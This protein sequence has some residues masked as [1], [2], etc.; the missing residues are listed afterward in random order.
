M[1]LFCWCYFVKLSEALYVVPRC[2]I[3]PRLRARQQ[4]SL[5]FF[6]EKSHIIENGSLNPTCYFFTLQN[7]M[8]YSNT[9][10]III[11]YLNTLPNTLDFSQ[12][13]NLLGS[14]SKSSTRTLKPRQLIRI[15]CVTQKNLR[16]LLGSRLQS[17]LYSFS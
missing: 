5:Q 13:R 17:A 4:K 2:K 10:P 15:E 7:P 8:A 1:A 3:Y 6:F 14:Q 11:P 16:A 9:L 12:R